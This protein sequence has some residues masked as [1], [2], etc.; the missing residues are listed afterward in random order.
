MSLNDWID[1][2]AFRN[3]L[4]AG[5]RLFLVIFY[6]IIGSIK[7]L[8]GILLAGLKIFNWFL[9]LLVGGNSK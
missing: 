4:T 6:L 7:I 1:L 2:I 3:F 5:Q 9:G 8:G